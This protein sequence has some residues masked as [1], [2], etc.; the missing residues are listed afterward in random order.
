VAACQARLWVAQGDVGAATRWAETCGLRVNDELDHRHEPE[1]I[2]LTRVLVA[3]GRLDEAVLV[4]ARLKEA[5]EAGGRIGHVL[6]IQVLLA[7]ALWARGDLIRAM[8]ELAQA[9]ALAE[10]E[11]Y[12]RTFVDEG[13]PM[14]AVLRTMSQQL[15]AFSQLQPYVKRLLAAFDGVDTSSPIQSPKSTIQRL[16]STRELEVLRLMAAGRSNAEIA[17]ALVVGLSTVKKH[18]NN[19]YAKLDVHSRTQAIA[20]ARDLRLL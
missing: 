6:E 1:H 3:Q 11:G 5:A 4:A 18:I 10:P 19:L 2:A 7:V 17:Q 15:S 16:L 14:G 20:R 8:S 12:I 13:A 9:L